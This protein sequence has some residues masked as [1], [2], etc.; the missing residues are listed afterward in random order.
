MST[1]FHWVWIRKGPDPNE[2]LTA[3]LCADLVQEFVNRLADALKPPC[4]RHRQGGCATN[5]PSAAIK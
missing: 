1:S 5:Q 4:L 3:R 2:R